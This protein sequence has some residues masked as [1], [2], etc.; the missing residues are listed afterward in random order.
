M[1]TTTR[2]LAH[3][4]ICPA[5]PVVIIPHGTA[6]QIV[7]AALDFAPLSGV[8]VCFC[9]YSHEEREH[10]AEHVIGAHGEC[11][12][13]DLET[14]RNSPDSMFRLTAKQM[15]EIERERPGEDVIAPYINF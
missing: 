15:D 4:W 7:N 8:W 10:M 1:T 6:S 3:G 11:F 14:F 5:S 12:D 13:A 2:Q 9:D